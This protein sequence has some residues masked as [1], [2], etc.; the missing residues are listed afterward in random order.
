MTSNI[1]DLPVAIIGGGPIGLAAAAHLLERGE[2]AALFEAGASVGSSI[3]DWGHVRLFSP[4]RYNMDSACMRLL[5]AAG[6]RAPEADALPSGDELIDQ[7]LL[8][9]SQLP[10]LRQIIHLNSRVIGISRR[11]LDKLKTAGRENTP[12]TLHVA[13][14]DSSEDIVHARAVIDASGAWKSPNPLGADGRPAI[15]ERGLRSRIRYGIPD[16]LG[17]ESGRYAGKR[18]LVVG[19]GHSAINTILDLLRLA[20]DAPGTSVV[21]ALRGDNL[22]RVYGGGDADALPARGQ[23]GSLMRRAVNAGLVETLS[24]FHIERIAESGAG[25]RV[26]GSLRGVSQSLAVDEIIACTG[27]RP[28]LDLTRELRLDLDPAVECSRTLAPMIDPNLHSCGTVPPHGEAEL[29]QPE[30]NYY[31][32]GMKSY[33]RA[34]TFLLATGYEQARSVAAALAGDWIAA[35]DVQLDLPETG[36]CVTDFDLDGCCATPVEC[37]A[38]VAISLDA[39][40]VRQDAA[41]ANRFATPKS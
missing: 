23:L 21:W 33:G 29:R 39:I 2:R 37:C 18:V 30:P 17:G 16:V 25:F 22:A 35:R 27:A 34:P 4:W 19:S 1:T 32:I 24:P 7:Y 26:A 14:T 6:W 31:A 12:F 9:L 5:E 36:V 13:R 11:G 20:E 38:P 3:R 8:P 41:E 10:R 28:D 15:G 40:A